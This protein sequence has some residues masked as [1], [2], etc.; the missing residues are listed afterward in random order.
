M[1]K[2]RPKKFSDIIGQDHVTRTLSNLI[3]S[4]NMHQTYIFSGP[5]GDGKTSSARILAASVNC[6]KGQTLEPC[7]ECKSCREIF[8]GTSSDVLEINAAS[9]RNIDDIRNLEDYVSTRPIG[10]GKKFV[11]FDECHSLTPQAAEAALKLLEEP[12]EW[13]CFI[14]CTT[15]I[16]K[17]KL[18]IHSRC[19]PF[20]FLKVSWP[21][22]LE[23]LKKIAQKE[24]YIFDEDALRIA[25]KL[26]KGSVRNSLNNLQ[27]LKTFAGDDK[28]TVDIAQKALGTIGNGNYFDLIDA[29]INKD[30][31][32]G[33]SVVQKIFIEGQD[34]DN[35]LNGL[36][37]HLRNLMVIFTSKNTSGL[38]FLSEDEQKKYIHQVD[39]MKTNSVLLPIK[40][41]ELLIDVVKAASLNINPQVLLDSFLLQSIITSASIERDAKK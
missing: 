5:F 23:H 1:L 35:I 18:T 31:S 34:F 9:T 21:Q 33:F 2:Y 11:I 41:I 26:S 4:G 40:M 17:M 10:R 38:L 22:I 37:E 24:G 30:A 19:M 3:T 13:V 16:Q 36:I 28:I 6:E 7:G 14:L 39:K 27:L 12:P 20:R 8:N 15:D 25:A 29:I 32:T